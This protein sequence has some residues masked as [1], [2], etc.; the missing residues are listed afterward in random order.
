[1][2]LNLHRI[3]AGNRMSQVVIHDGTAYLAGQVA[4]GN[5][6]ESVA[7]Q[8]AAILTQVDLLLAEAGS[9]KSLLLFATIWL[10]DLATFDEMNAVWEA[11][12]TPGGA[13]ARATIGAR[14]A[15]PGVTVEIAVVAAVPPT[16]G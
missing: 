11:W 1:M 3:R 2:S 13:P 16:S 15:L 4:L 9:H 7:D 12:L 8:T 5:R 6:G 10:T 14:L